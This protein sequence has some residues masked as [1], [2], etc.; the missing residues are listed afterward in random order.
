LDTA[1]SEHELLDTALSLASVSIYSNPPS[2]VSVEME[3]NDKDLITAN[4]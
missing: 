2:E 1:L 4:R 3:D